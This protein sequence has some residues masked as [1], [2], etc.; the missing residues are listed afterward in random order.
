[1]NVTLSDEIRTLWKQYTVGLPKIAAHILCFFLN[2]IFYGCLFIDISHN[3]TVQN[4]GCDSEPINCTNTRFPYNCVTMWMS[5][6]GSTFP[7]TVLYTTDLPS[8]LYKCNAQCDIRGT[9]CS[10]LQQ[11]VNLNCAQG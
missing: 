10:I 7:N 3:E 9:K 1:M 11:T 4:I 6:N 8:G 5:Q 2:S